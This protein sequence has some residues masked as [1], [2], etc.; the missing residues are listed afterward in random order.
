M[1][2]RKER[3]SSSI[4]ILFAVVGVL[5]AAGIVVTG[6]MLAPASAPPES[7]GQPPGPDQPSPSAPAK[8]DGDRSAAAS[9]PSS[10][11]AS[12]TSPD[13]AKEPPPDNS[14]AAK[15][16]REALDEIEALEESAEFYQALQR[17]WEFRKQA[18]LT[19]QRKHALTACERRL[20]RE[21][22]HAAQ[23]TETLTHLGADVEAVREAAKAKLK[24]AGDV[25]RIYLRKAVRTSDKVAVAE[26]LELLLEMDAP[27]ASAAFVDRLLREPDG[28]CATMLR[29]ALATRI[30][31][32]IEE[33]RARLSDALQRIFAAVRA[34]A[35]LAHTGEAGLLT[36]AL[37]AWYGGRAEPFNAFL[38]SET[39]YEDLKQYVERA[40]GSSDRAVAEWAFEQAAAFG[41][42]DLSED[43]MGWWRLDQKHGLMVKD[44]SGME[45]T[46][47]LEGGAAWTPEGLQLKPSAGDAYIVLPT[48]APLNAVQEGDYTLAAW[49]KPLSAPPG[50]GAD[51]N[52]SY[53]ILVKAGYHLGLCYTHDRR[54]TMNHWLTK[55]QSVGVTSERRFE[56]ETFHHVLG[57]VNPTAG[58]VRLY[59][60]GRAEG[61]KS[62]AAETAA[63]A[64]GDTPWRIGIARPGSDSYRWPAHGVLSDVRI[65]GRAVA[66]RFARA[67]YMQ[68]KRTQP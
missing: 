25:G 62:F 2:Q 37:S 36:R 64:Y 8:T 63:R 34:D 21:R 29:G 19:P 4:E 46:G 33:S 14:P 13:T 15:A 51:N 65:Y 6:L 55:D 3:K 60:N 5:V 17:L 40:R 45:H 56:V 49:F 16:F 68:S 10:S 44:H 20:Q 28:P 1:R 35:E 23:L 9:A 30:R 22:L 50:H 27:K 31:Q 38:E 39:A 26:A 18:D 57:V 24:D 61:A 41:L 52:A 66:P 12:E 11:D 53:A 48:T 32:A 67:L 59:V 58:T 47:R 54:F 43:L 42:L 7:G